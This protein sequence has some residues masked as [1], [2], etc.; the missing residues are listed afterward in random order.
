[1][2]LKIH[3]PYLPMSVTAPAHLPSTDLVAP[4]ERPL[5]PHMWNANCVVGQIG[6]NVHPNA[7]AVC[8]V[9]VGVQQRLA[10]HGQG[11]TLENMQR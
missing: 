9:V 10:K 5:S 2:G 6:Q 3:T 8:L 4:S 1:M 7:S 11:R